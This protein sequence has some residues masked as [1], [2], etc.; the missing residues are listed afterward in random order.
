MISAIVNSL[1]CSLYCLFHWD[2]SIATI[3]GVLKC[4]DSFPWKWIKKT[5]CNHSWVI[6]RI[7][8]AALYSPWSPCLGTQALDTGSCIS[9]ASSLS[10]FSLT[11][12]SKFQ[13]SQIW[14]TLI[15]TWILI[16]DL[17]LSHIK[18][19]FCKHNNADFHTLVAFHRQSLFPQ[20]S[21]LLQ[22]PSCV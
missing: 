14:S 12:S 5:T 11:Q 17:D 2:I 4:N 19:M 20:C 9:S 7:L 13:P 21:T 18:L 15:G 3:K 1:L 10:A 6:L 16:L 22:V 8:A